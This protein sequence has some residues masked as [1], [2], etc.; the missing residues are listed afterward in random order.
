MRNLTLLIVSLILLCASVLSIR[1][2]WADRLRR[3]SDPNLV[4][5][6]TEL[7]S[8]NAQAFFSRAQYDEQQGKDAKEAW[9]RA[10]DLDPRNPRILIQAGISSE[11]RGDFKEAEQRYLTAERF[12]ALWLPR[13]TLANFYFRQGSY[14]ECLRW[15]KVALERCQSFDSSA[16][17]NLAQDAGADPARILKDLVPPSSLLATSAY[18]YWIGREQLTDNRASFLTQAANKIVAGAGKTQENSD[19]RYPIFFATRKLAE[20]GFGDQARNLWRSACRSEF[21]ECATP[22]D[23]GLIGNGA[24]SKPFLQS[25]M[26]WQISQ[27]QGFSANQQMA[28]GTLKLNL[29]GDQPETTALLSQTLALRAGE[30][31]KV[32]F[33]FQTREIAS[34]EA[35]GLEWLLQDHVLALSKP[36]SSE[37]WDE[38]EFHIDA[39]D[40]DTTVP[41]ILAYRRKPGTVRIRGDLWIRSIQARRE[42]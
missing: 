18:V 33:E 17:F 23:D 14:N 12:N 4:N 37:F 41:L 39:Q 22:P 20:G 9:Q 32:R 19:W 38:A 24:F 15:I 35:V 30:R 11:I 27:V 5:R 26:D 40:R 6:A 21:L 31:W 42:K 7:N 25:P 8:L 10:I 3:T 36:L 28:S 16:V 34:R 1:I 2:A 13:W 29:T